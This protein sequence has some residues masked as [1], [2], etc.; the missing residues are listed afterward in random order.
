M[1]DRVLHI[2]ELTCSDGTR[3]QL[4]P[5][6]ILIVVG[7]NNSGKSQ[8]LIDIQASLREHRE[9]RESGKVVVSTKESFLYGET[10][11]NRLSKYERIDRNAYQLFQT[12]VPRGNV[13]NLHLA[14]DFHSVAPFFFTRVNVENRLMMVQPAKP[15]ENYQIPSPIAAVFDD[16][17]LTNKVSD[18]LRA[19]FNK[20]LFFDYRNLGEIPA[21]IGNKPEVPVGCDRV[22]NEYVNLVRGCEKLHE[23]GDGI[24]SFAG[25]V[26]SIFA[27][28]YDV[29]L[30]D[31]PEAFLH[32]PQERKLG[33]IF[34]E[35][36]DSQLVISTHSKSIIQ[37]VLDQREENVQ[38][39]RLV[40]DGEINRVSHLSSTQIANLWRDPV[41]RYSTALEGLFHDVV[42]LCEAEADCKF[43]E[44]LQ[45]EV[46]SNAPLDTHYIPC[47]GKAGFPKFIAAMREL[48]IP[49]KAILDFDVLNDEQTIKAI[50]EAQGGDWAQIAYLWRRIDAQIKADVRG[51]TIS[52]VKEEVS[53]LLSGWTEGMPPRSKVDE[54]FKATKP[55]GRLKRL[56]LNGL[57]AG[58]IQKDAEELLSLLHSF[59]VYPIEVGTLEDFVKTVP[60]HGLSWLNEVFRSFSLNDVKLEQARK[61]I[62][63]VFAS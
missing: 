22:S 58:Q 49:T 45:I 12:V 23:Q 30:I 42:V 11:K 46:Q 18:L 1:S 40:R 15:S 39:V 3:I 29:L 28:R 27:A 10:A 57:P 41:F 4:D 43:F 19:A 38:V 52:E 48:S 61:F 9:R 14:N 32:P 51:L 8:F 63:L 60:G 59:Q 6:D 16:D 24:K 21:Y 44:A 20:S 17:G 55:W 62:K 7:P 47:G 34:A 31:E 54:A 37:G 56:G 35:V 53:A 25:I 5:N 36:A 50:F 33:R 13:S 2:E 26:L